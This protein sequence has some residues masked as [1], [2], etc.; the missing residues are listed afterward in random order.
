MSSLGKGH[1]GIAV[2]S[3]RTVKLENMRM[4]YNFQRTLIHERLINGMCIQGGFLTTEQ[5]EGG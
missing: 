1:A 3:V 5:C 4:G 2:G